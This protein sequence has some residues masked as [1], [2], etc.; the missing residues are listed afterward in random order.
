MTWNDVARMMWPTRP[1]ARESTMGA[2]QDRV[3]RNNNSKQNVTTVAA[4]RTIARSAERE[5]IIHPRGA[6][7][8]ACVTVL[9]VVEGAVTP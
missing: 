9:V 8:A 4:E 7:A 2:R 5:R 1:S 3:S 6:A